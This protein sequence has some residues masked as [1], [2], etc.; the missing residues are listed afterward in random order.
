MTGILQS[1]L[2]VMSD[3]LLTTPTVADMPRVSAMWNMSWDI[4]LASYALLIVLAGAIVMGFETV[5]TR[6]GLREITPRIVIGFLAGALSM[7]IAG[8][9]I[10]TANGLSRAVLTTGFDSPGTGGSGGD[11]AGGLAKVISQSLDGDN[12]SVFVL[13]LALFLVVAVAA[14]LLTWVVRVS[15]TVLLLAA[16]PIALM[17]HALPQTEHIARWWW[18]TFTACLAIQVVQA[19]TLVIG[20]Q[21]LLD[22]DG[23]TGVFDTDSDG[24]IT[25]LV[26]LVLCYLL[27]KIPIWLLSGSRIGGRSVIGS[28]VRS[29]LAVKTFGALRNLGG[30]G[31]GGRQGKGRDDPGDGDDPGPPPPPPRPPDPYARVRA[32]RGGQL[33]LPLEGLRRHRR[34]PPT[35][36]HPAPGPTG[37]HKP[38]PGRDRRPPQ[39]GVQLALPLEDGWPED[40][41]RLMRDGQY[42][43]PINATRVPAPPPPQPAPG[44]AR[45]RNR[46]RRPVQ[47]A[48]PLTDGWPEDQPRVTRGGQYALPI[49]VTRTPPRAT[50]SRTGSA[51]AGS[52]GRTAA[53]SR[54]PRPRRTAG[55]QLALPLDDD[56]YQGNRPLR[57]G[58][59]PLPLD[60]TRGPRRPRTPPP[61]TTPQP[62]PRPAP[63][64]RPARPRQLALPIPSTPAPPPAPSAPPAP[65]AAQA[66]TTP[67]T[68]T[69]PARTRPTA[70]PTTAAATTRRRRTP[71]PPPVL[72]PAPPAVPP[73]VPPVVP[74][75]S[76]ASPASSPP[77]RKRAPKRRPASSSSPSPASSPDSP[78]PP[79]PPAV[80]PAPAPGPPSSSDPGDFR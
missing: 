1:L 5:Q 32:L 71:Q 9:G 26:V 31:Q 14:I 13:V 72:P 24:L 75:T 21:V 36:P 29:Y 55:R 51:G 60:V 11:P 54:P 74:P 19:F 49:D 37:K 77:S 61:G 34:L 64:R 41:P 18:R 79:V 6:Y 35:P 39:R 10:D 25:V 70:G 7:V 73:V 45:A 65:A 28:M 63:A 40:R 58:Q 78:P 46:G 52:A 4:L 27:V 16:A 23:G 20:L 15:I 43:L 30:R 3:H 53:A 48:L 56:P 50:P 80:P 33:M 57:S 59:Y 62:P 17:F 2:S 8:I 44:P 76:A 69:R 22:P 68:T 38:G 42:A 66:A 67:T 47:L 12:A